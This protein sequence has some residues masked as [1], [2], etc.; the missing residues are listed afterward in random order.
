[1]PIYTPGG[2]KIRVEPG[3]AFALLSRLEPKVRPYDVLRTTE[4]I[5]RIPSALAVGA[6]LVVLLRGDGWIPLAV[7]T[8]VAR[9]LGGFI[10][11]NGLFVIPGLIL[12]GQAF[13]LL[14]PFGIGFLALVVFAAIRGGPI[15][16]ATFLLATLGAGAINFAFETRKARRYHQQGAA[17]FTGSEVN[18]FNAYRLAAT[19]LGL[20]TDLVVTEEEAASDRA[21]A[22]FVRFATDHPDIVSRFSVGG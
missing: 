12:L 16:A 17:P 22:S 21:Q 5:E 13:R 2:L 15:V 1:M 11:R 6:A 10:V 4:A 20:S 7:V 8:A 14:S 19:R 9:L 3:Y 18:F